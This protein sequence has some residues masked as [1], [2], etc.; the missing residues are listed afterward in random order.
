MTTDK[1]LYKNL[2]YKVRGVI[3]KIYNQLGFGHKENIY[4]RALSHELVKNKI[5]FEEEK[6]LDVSYDGI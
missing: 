1:L 5:E 4:R 2:T 3:F 6:A